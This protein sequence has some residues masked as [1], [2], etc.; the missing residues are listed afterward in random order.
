VRKVANSS[1]VRKIIVP[2]NTIKE[3]LV[4]FGVCSDKIQVIPTTI[5]SISHEFVNG[6][7]GTAHLRKKIGIDP[8][9]YVITYFGSPCTLRGTDTIVSSLRFLVPRL[10]KIELVILSRLSRNAIR[11]DPLKREEEYLRKLAAK[12]KVEHR[13]R[14][15]SGLLDRSSLTEYICASDAVVLP[16]KIVQSE[17]PLALLEAMNLE[18]V[19]VTSNVG[20]LADVIGRDRGILVEPSHA[21]WLAEAILFL[22]QHP[23]YARHMTKRAK[24]FVSRL[25]SWDVGLSCLGSH[26]SRVGRLIRRS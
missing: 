10:D 11:N 25:P 21:C 4:S 26:G 9:N 18:R 7:E 14:I 13:M 8:A 1:L 19:V 23:K 22:A 24:E 3:D 17:T 20:A 5:D 15:V 2:G 16:F 12:L 6:H